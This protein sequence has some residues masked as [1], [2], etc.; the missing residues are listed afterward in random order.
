MVSM[1]SMVSMVVGID[2][3]KAKLVVS[4]LPS[5]ERFTVA[6]DD[7]GGRPLVER[8]RPIEVTLIVLEATGGYELLAVA[9]LAEV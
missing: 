5:A 7:R 2:V 8:L 9:G 4:V 6:N 3:A 1:V